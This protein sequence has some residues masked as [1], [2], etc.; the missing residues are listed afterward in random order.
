MKNEKIPKDYEIDLL[1]MSGKTVNYSNYTYSE[2]GQYYTP[3]ETAQE[4]FNL[5]CEVLRQFKEEEANFHYIEPSVGNGVFL[6]VLPK[7]RTLLGLD[8]E[9]RINSVPVK[10]SKD[11]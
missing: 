8:I 10:E 2:K 11:S 9:P 5:F 3:E 7:D 4:C 6:N 1:I